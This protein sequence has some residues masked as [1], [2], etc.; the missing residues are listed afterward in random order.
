MTLKRTVMIFTLV[1]SLALSSCASEQS[2]A[3]TST[4]TYASTFTPLPTSTNTPTFTPTSTSTST[5]TPDITIEKAISFSAPILD[6]IS[7]IPPNFQDDFTLANQ[8]WY[9]SYPRKNGRFDIDQGKLCIF[10][11]SSTPQVHV[12]NSQLWHGNFVIDVTA[13][14]QSYQDASAQILWRGHHTFVLWTARRTWNT[15]LCLVNGCNPDYD[16]GYDTNIKPFTPMRMTVINDGSAFALYLTGQPL[17][18]V[19]DPSVRPTEGISLIDWSLTPAEVCY[20]QF[21]MWNLGAIHIP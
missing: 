10:T 16:N 20:S 2:I 1:L 8:G 7:K 9:I 15:R 4:P 14:I 18:Y 19:D 21:K 17:T 11:D 13:Y 6:A 12:S 5:P 3:T